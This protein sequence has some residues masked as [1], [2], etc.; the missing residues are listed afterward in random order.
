M[1]EDEIQEWQRQRKLECL[2]AQ[3]VMGWKPKP[4]QGQE[5]W[6]AYLWENPTGESCLRDDPDGVPY[7][8][9]S[10]DAAWLVVEHFGGSDIGGWTYTQFYQLLRGSCEPNPYDIDDKR[11]HIWLF[12]ITPELICRAA[13]K[14][15]EVEL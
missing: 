14:A 11:H 5:D 15:V 13:L 6:E 12:N 8:A 1:N 2:V 10:M 4:S 3:H 9:R 7:Y